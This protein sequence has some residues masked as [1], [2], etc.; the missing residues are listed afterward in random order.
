[1]KTL[2]SFVLKPGLFSCGII[3]L[4]I[5]CCVCGPVFAARLAGTDENVSTTT[6]TADTT[7]KIIE[8]APSKTAASVKQDIPSVK[9][10]KEVKAE[11]A[12]KESG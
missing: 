1:M 9:T 2:H 10:E 5:I 6:T 7:K 11:G 8:A 3:A 12:I 4:I